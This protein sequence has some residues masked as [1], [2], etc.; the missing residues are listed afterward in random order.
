MVLNVNIILKFAVKQLTEKWDYSGKK[1]G[2]IIQ[3]KQ[4]MSN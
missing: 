2:T 4:G 3:Q 1:K